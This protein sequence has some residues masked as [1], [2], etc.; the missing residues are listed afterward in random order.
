MIF[1]EDSDF[2]M[3][4]CG[5]L[6]SMFIHILH[7]SFRVPQGSFEIAMKSMSD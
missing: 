1:T 2:V 5:E 6:S 4:R 3:F 7:G